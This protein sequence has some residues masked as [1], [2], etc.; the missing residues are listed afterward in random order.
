MSLPRKDGFIK[1]YGFIDVSWVCI[2]NSDQMG[3]FSDN[4]LQ[5][6]KSLGESTKRGPFSTAF[7]SLVSTQV[8]SSRTEFT[9]G[10]RKSRAKLKMVFKFIPFLTPKQAE[11]LTT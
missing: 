4:F 11:N 8:P 10:P 3:P 9:N 2:A 5:Y 6:H 7:H 1:E